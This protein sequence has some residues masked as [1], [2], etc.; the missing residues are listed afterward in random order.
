MLLF[1]LYCPGPLTIIYNVYKSMTYQE[2]HLYPL[3]ILYSFKIN[4]NGPDDA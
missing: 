2:V 3:F 1:V 4:I